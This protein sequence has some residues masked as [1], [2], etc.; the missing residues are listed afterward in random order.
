V[1]RERRTLGSVY[2]GNG[3]LH[4]G[5]DGHA[6]SDERH[7]H[8]GSASA[9]AR[10]R[11]SLVERNRSR[12][13]QVGRW[14]DAAAGQAGIEKKQTGRSLIHLRLRDD[15]MVADEIAGNDGSVYGRRGPL[16]F[17]GTAGRAHT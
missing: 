3:V 7:T 10:G 8:H 16:E 11:M 2:S 14:H 1:N 17:G 13:E 4:R 9:H 15:E 6:T 12:F 5:S